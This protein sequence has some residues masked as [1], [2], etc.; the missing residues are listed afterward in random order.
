[1]SQLSYVNLVS[2]MPITKATVTFKSIQEEAIAIAEIPMPST[3]LD[4]VLIILERPSLSKSAL[5]KINTSLK[6]LPLF[7]NGFSDS[8]KKIGSNQLISWAK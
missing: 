7:S 5:N 1:M 4:S 6:S 2:R 3:P 8:M